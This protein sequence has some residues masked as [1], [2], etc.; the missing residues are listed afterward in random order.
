MQRLARLLFRLVGWRTEGAPPPND[1]YVVIA[2][3][4]TSNWDAD[5]L[6]VAA[7]I[8]VCGIAWFG[9]KA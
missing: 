6:L 7:R 8:S 3:P 2:A 1:R 5:I 4:H 9:K